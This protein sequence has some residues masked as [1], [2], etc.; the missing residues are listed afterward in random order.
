LKVLNDLLSCGGDKRRKKSK[1]FLQNLKGYSAHFNYMRNEAD[2]SDVSPVSSPTSSPI[3][4]PISPLNRP[5]SPVNSPINSPLTFHHNVDSNSSCSDMDSDISSEVDS[6]IDSP[7]NN[8]I[9]T[10]IKVEQVVVKSEKQCSTLE[11]LIFTDEESQYISILENDLLQSNTTTPHNVDNTSN[12]QQV[13][14]TQNNNT[15]TYMNS[16]MNQEIDNWLM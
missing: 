13:H 3:N 6:D 9:K 5:V 11:P 14:Q 10:Q 15:E 2:S 4:R 12:V 1:Q 16:L 8:N 7:K